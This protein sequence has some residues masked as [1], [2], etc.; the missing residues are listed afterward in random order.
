MIIYQYDNE[1]I[2]ISSSS[3]S[4]SSKKEN[5]RRENTFT[6]RLFHSKINTINI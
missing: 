1:N 4:S 5:E 3:S 2:I 6:L